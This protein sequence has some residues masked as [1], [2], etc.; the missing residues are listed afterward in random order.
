VRG[1]ASSLKVTISLASQTDFRRVILDVR[2]IGLF[3]NTSPGCGLSQLTSQTRLCLA[4][5]NTSVVHNPSWCDNVVGLGCSLRSA[6]QYLYHRY[7]SNSL[8]EERRETP[9]WWILESVTCFH[10]FKWCRWIGSLP[11]DFDLSCR[12]RIVCHRTR[13]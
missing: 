6:C 9:Y 11:V 10:R 3:T 5:F 13:R 4:Q 8:R 7:T 12:I 2:P 1:A